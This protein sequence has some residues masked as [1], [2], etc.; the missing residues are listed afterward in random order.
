MTDKFVR[1]F[2]PATAQRVAPAAKR[3]IM[4]A[5]AMLVEMHPA[6]VNR[7]GRFVRGRLHAPQATQHC[8][9]MALVQT[10]QGGFNPFNS[11]VGI[12]AATGKVVEI[13]VAAALQDHNGLCICNF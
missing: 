4:G 9:D 7:F 5:A 8:P 10:G 2:D 3:A 11:P 1:R 12:V 6:V 13:V